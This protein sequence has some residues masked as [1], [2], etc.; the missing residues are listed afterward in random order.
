MQA[1][2]ATGKV[3]IHSLNYQTELASNI[4][5]RLC[6]LALHVS[7][8][9]KDAQHESR[10]V[11]IVHHILSCR[12]QNALVKTLDFCGYFTPVSRLYGRMIGKC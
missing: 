10:T 4:L 5:R 8:I 6:R 1:C 7:L 11:Y 3:Q 12:T 9:Y 2:P